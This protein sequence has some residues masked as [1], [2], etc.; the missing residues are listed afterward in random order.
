ARASRHSSA[1]GRRIECEIMTPPETGSLWPGGT[2]AREAHRGE[3]GIRGRIT[4]LS[5][6]ATARTMPRI[7]PTFAAGRNSPLVPV[8]VSPKSCW[9][10]VGG[11]MRS[12]APDTPDRALEIAQLQIQL[13]VHPGQ[14][15]SHASHAL[16]LVEGVG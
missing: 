13:S 3:K 6:W 8:R 4:S 16:D 2:G 1:S 12:Y 7:V 11:R 5:S 15:R 10:G 14:A 9:R